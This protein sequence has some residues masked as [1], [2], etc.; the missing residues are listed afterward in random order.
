MYQKM[1]ESGGKRRGDITEDKRVRGRE[2]GGY[3][4]R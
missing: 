4:R 1:K 2:K 3:Y